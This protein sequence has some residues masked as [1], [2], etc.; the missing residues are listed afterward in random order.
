MFNKD[1]L[2]Q[3]KKTNISKDGEKTKERFRKLYESAT[4]DQKV[5]IRNLA[6]VVKPTIYRIYNTGAITARLAIAIAQS[7]NVDPSYLTGEVDVASE[8]TDDNL[9]AFLRKHGYS[10]LLPKNAAPQKKSRGKKATSESVQPETEEEAIARFDAEMKTNLRV[11]AED[12]LSKH[13][14]EI[15]TVSL[16]QLQSESVASLSD[17]DLLT[18]FRSLRLRADVGVPGTQERLTKIQELLLF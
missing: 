1:F 9:E 16:S 7:L 14:Y 17:D 8:C 13:G 11:A 4:P 6:D 2:K 5:S 12:Y 3:L 15:V 10:K 18:L